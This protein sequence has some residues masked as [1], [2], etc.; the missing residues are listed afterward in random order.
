MSSVSP[1]NSTMDAIRRKVRRLTA[2]PSE[3]T[4]RQSDIDEAVNTFYTQDFPSA[5]KTDQLKSE[6]EV[7][8]SPNVDRY[9]V[10]I[11]SIINFRQPIY[12]EGKQSIFFKTKQEFYRLF[13]RWPS[14]TVAGLGDGTTTS[15]T[16]NVGGPFLSK[17]VVIGTTDAGG[18]SVQISDDGDGNL[19]LINFNT[20]TG[21]TI[22]TV[23]G[24]VSYVSGDF[25]VVFPVAPGANESID[26]WVSTYQAGYP[27]CALFYNNEIIL[28]P[29]P[30]A[31]YKLE[32]ETYKTPTEFLESTNEPTLQQWWQYIAYGAAIEI[33]RD[34]QDMEGIQELMEGFNRQEA[35][36]LERQANEEI[37]VANDTIF[38]SPNGFNTGGIFFGDWY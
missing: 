26:V 16:F 27:Y 32:I 5:I 11:N 6:L 22:K 36:V 21:D 34:R 19:E 2:S 28:R 14:R 20:D 35:M 9:R 25:N 38:N 18:S 31:V 15:F 30:D 24:S 13:P 10:N 7:F 1:P 12:V 37:G 3:N 4:L 23:I 33:L 17:N 8:T 29:V